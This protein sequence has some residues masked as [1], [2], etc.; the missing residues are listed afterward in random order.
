MS[1]PAPFPFARYRHSG[2]ELLGRPAWRDG[3]CRRGYGPPVFAECGTACAYCD[4]QL[5]ESYESWLDLS[6]DH[7]VPGETVKRL[8]WPREWID[9]IVNLVTC[10]RACNEFLNGYRVSDPPPASFEDFIVLRDQ[11]FSAKRTWVINRHVRERAWYD[12]WVEG[13]EAESRVNRS[14]LRAEGSA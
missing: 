7:V 6:I 8:G 11:H 5:G 14:S 13:R 12:A 9:D 2:R 4:R 1:D 3:S 10:C